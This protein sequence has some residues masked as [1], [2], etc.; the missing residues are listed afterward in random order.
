VANDQPL[1]LI[2]AQLA[3]AAWTGWRNDLNLAAVANVSVT[4]SAMANAYQWRNKYV[5]ALAAVP[6]K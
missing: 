3:G 2:S 6:A 1:Q 5:M 4:V